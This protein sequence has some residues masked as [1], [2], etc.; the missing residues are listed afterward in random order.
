[1]RTCHIH[2]L[3]SDS[4]PSSYVHRYLNLQLCITACIT[5]WD[6]DALVNTLAYTYIEKFVERMRAIRRKKFKPW[7][8]RPHVMKPLQPKTS[9]QE[10]KYLYMTAAPFRPAGMVVPGNQEDVAQTSVFSRHYV[11][12]IGEILT[13]AYDKFHTKI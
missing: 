8:K 2:V 11:V 6:K 9:I 13:L 1:M 3:S 12:C 10:K 7:L 4:Y 5:K